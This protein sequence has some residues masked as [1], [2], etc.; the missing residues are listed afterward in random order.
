MPL[1]VSFKYFIDYL[2]IELG[3][4]MSKN[5]KLQ[6][7]MEYLMTYGWAILVIAIVLVALYALGVFNGS[8]FLHPSCIASSGYICTNQTASPSVGNTVQVGFSFGQNSGSPVYNAIIGVSPQASGSQASG[9]PMQITE[10]AVCT[11]PCTL[12]AGNIQP[13]FISVPANEFSSGNQIGS[14]F[15]GYVWLNYSTTSTGPSINTAKV[16]TLI[17]KVT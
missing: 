8:A 11:E 2:S 15:N 10:N 17:I 16:A 14:E 3:A 12:D 1:L 9:F 13:V 6:S 5:F 7:A 4:D